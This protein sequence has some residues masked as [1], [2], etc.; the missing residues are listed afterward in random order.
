MAFDGP[1]YVN[2]TSEKSID[3]WTFSGSF[4]FVSLLPIR[5]ETI[6]DDIDELRD[7]DISMG[8]PPDL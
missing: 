2:D 4:S 6:L 1:I 8:I 5:N 7:F 3:N